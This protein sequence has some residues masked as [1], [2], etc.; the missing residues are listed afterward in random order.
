MGSSTYVKLRIVYYIQSTLGYLKDFR[1][2]CL[3]VSGGDGMAVVN[4][5]IK[6]GQTIQ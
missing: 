6:I 4:K 1:D 3:P 5:L 2:E